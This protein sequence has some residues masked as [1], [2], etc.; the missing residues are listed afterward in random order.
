MERAFVDTSAWF[1]YAN[2]Q[3]PD[4]QRIRTVLQTFQGRLITS[5]FI[6]DETVTLCLYRLGHQVAATVGE[7]LRDPMAFQNLTSS[8]HQGTPMP[9]QRS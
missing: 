1:A 5:N 4:H 9:D 8:D 2:R 7:V 6:F 3:D